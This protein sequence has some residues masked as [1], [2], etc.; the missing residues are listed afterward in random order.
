MK[1]CRVMDDIVNTSM[2]IRELT[3]SGKLLSDY[4]YIDIEDKKSHQY[5]G[6]FVSNQYAEEVKHFIESRLKEKQ[7]K[8]L[9]E[10][11]QFA[12]IARGDTENKNIQTLKADKA[13][14]YK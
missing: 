4:N 12:G 7:E 6:V 9:K 14:K 2:S 1:L 11:L 10:L 13:D 8:K 3:R 5:K